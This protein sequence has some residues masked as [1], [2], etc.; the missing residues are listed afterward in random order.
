[1]AASSTLFSAEIQWGLAENGL[2]LGIDVTATPEPALRVSLKN[3]GVEP[4]DLVIGEEGAV[5]LYNVEIATRNPGQPEQRV[6]DLP[7]LQ[8]SSSSLLLPISA[9]L[10]PGE[11]REFVYPL[12]QLICVVNR[13]D[14]PFRALFEHGYNVHASFEFPGVTLVTPEL[15]YMW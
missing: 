12:N 10:Q 4:R 13:K 2:Q 6:F 14:V 11:V 3:V 15:T 9:R 8:V 7:A 1:M 5:D